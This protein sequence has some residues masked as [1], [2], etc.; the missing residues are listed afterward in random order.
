MG[1]FRPVTGYGTEYVS[2]LTN[3]TA[4]LKRIRVDPAYH[5]RGYGQQIYDRLEKR[6]RNR[7]Y[8]EFVLDTTPDQVGA[9]QFFETN[10]FT[11]AAHVELDPEFLDDAV[12]L[13]LFRKSI[14]S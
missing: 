2:G 13:V 12:E 1:T 11:E 4:E 5:R 14:E 8:D 10:G 9:R 7:G 6:A 3:G